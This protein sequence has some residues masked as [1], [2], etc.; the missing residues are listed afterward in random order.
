[1]PLRSARRRRRLIVAR[2]FYVLAGLL[3]IVGIAVT[4]R[5]RPSAPARAV[6]ALRSETTNPPALE[7]VTPLAAVG[8]ANTPPV[9]NSPNIVAVAP[10]GTTTI[11]DLWLTDAE[12]HEEDVFGV[13][14]A[15]PSGR[16]SLATTRGL[17]LYRPN[18]S[19]SISFSGPLVAVNAALAGLQYRPGPA[20]GERTLFIVATDFGHQKRYEPLTDRRVVLLVVRP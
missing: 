15:A 16:L 19:R 6:P 2:G 17:R 10:S 9:I 3:V 14:V 13:L 8:L 5:S 1:M 4:F 12:A 7:P 20:K 18:G 11:P